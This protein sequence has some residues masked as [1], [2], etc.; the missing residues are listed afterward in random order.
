MQISVEDVFNNARK[1]NWHIYRVCKN[2]ASH[3][4]NWTAKGVSAWE[5][6]IFISGQNR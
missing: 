1:D 4:R 5:I 3:T 2:A 6:A